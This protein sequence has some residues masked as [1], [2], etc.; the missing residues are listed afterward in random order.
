MDIYNIFMMKTPWADSEKKRQDC[1]LIISAITELKRISGTNIRHPLSHSSLIPVQHTQTEWIKASELK[2]SFLIADH[3]SSTTIPPP[4][5]KN[6]GFWHFPKKLAGM[7][8]L[9]SMQKTLTQRGL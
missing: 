4:E 6:P 3:R 1:K 7:R 9:C 5:T 2:R 8:F